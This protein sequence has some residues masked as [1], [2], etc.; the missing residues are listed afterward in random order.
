MMPRPA[1]SVLLLLLLALAPATPA[2]A[3]LVTVDREKDYD[4]Q[5]MRGWT[6]KVNKRLLAPRH[7]ALRKDVLEKV[8]GVEARR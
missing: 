2:A 4:V 7:D 6:L 1:A 5:K 8:W 3:P